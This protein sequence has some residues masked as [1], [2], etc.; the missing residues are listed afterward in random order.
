[1]SGADY[2][3]IENPQALEV[4][5]HHLHDVEV[6]GGLARFT[7]VVLKTRR[8]EP[9]AEHVATVVLPTQAVEPALILTW[10]KLPTGVIVPTLGKIVR[11]ALIH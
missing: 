9:L 10:S 2:R 7:L 5:G 4:T 3:F 11:R 1:M 6:V 8:G